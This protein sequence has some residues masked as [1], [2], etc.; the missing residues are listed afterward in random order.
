MAPLARSYQGQGHAQGV[1][2]APVQRKAVGLAVRSALLA[3]NDLGP[4][5][6]SSRQ[7][8][9]KHDDAHKVSPHSFR[10]D[11]HGRRI[12]YPSE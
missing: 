7:Y 9:I 11:L 12:T 5:Q 8:K 3:A 6:L 10:P 1:H 2:P 4:D